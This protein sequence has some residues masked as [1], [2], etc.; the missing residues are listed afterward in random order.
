M[1]FDTSSTVNSEGHVKVV[2]EVEGVYFGSFVVKADDD[3]WMFVHPPVKFTF[4]QADV[5]LTRMIEEGEI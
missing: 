2:F 1:K 5:M 4:E 3:A